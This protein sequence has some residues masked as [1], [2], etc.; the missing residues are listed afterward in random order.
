MS[1][2]INLDYFNFEKNIIEKGIF[3]LIFYFKFLGNHI[4][5]FFN[6]NMS[7]KHTNI[8]NDKI[9]S[10]EKFYLFFLRF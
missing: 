6:Q 2:D 5:A 8:T 10:G 3:N 1:I 9:L 4:Y 7:I